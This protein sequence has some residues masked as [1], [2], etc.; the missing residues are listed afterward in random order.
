MLVYSEFGRRVEENASAGTDH[1][2]SAPMFAFGDP[3]IGGIYGPNDDLDHLDGDGNLIH[4]IDFRETYATIL[5]RWLGADQ[6]QILGATFTPVP[7]L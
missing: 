2:T 7:F 6:Q 5:D 1:G 3:V 4:T